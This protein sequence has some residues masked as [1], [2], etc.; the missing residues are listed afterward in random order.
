MV[1]FVAW[2]KTLLVYLLQIVDIYQPVFDKEILSLKCTLSEREDKVMIHLNENK[3]GH[4]IDVCLNHKTIIILK[5]LIIL[6]IIL[7]LLIII[8]IFASMYHYVNSTNLK[9]RLML[10]INMP[11][12][13]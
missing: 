13:G 10:L 4:Y 9:R 11:Y 3:Y 6:L 2:P 12:N 5:I 1:Q 7:L 8:I